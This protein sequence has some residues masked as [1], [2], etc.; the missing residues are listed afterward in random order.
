MIA[1][2]VIIKIYFEISLFFCFVNSVVFSLIIV[3][4]PEQYCASITEDSNTD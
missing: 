1:C 2:S 3:E 4:S